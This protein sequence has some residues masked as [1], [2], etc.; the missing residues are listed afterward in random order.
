MA[1]LHNAATHNTMATTINV[2]KTPI[3]RIICIALLLLSTVPICAGNM[4]EATICHFEGDLMAGDVLDLEQGYRLAI[5]DIR[6]KSVMISIFDCDYEIVNTS[7]SGDYTFAKEIDGIDYDILRM[8]ITATG[9]DVAAIV[10]EQYADKDKSFDYPL[11]ACISASIRE[12]ERE[13]LKA[14]YGLEVTS[15]IDNNA[16]LSLYKDDKIVKQEKLNGS[17][18]ERFIYARKVDGQYRTILIAKLDGISD[19]SVHLSELSQFEEPVDSDGDCDSS[20]KWNVKLA[21][22]TEF[23]YLLST[24]VLAGMFALILVITRQMRR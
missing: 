18:K 21:R 7:I 2:M 13:A 11:I 6:K 24:G 22:S 14:G 1:L 20:D 23:R 4:H 9:D 16:I 12:G 15:V 3:L 10:V 8:S 5:D 19:G 17:D